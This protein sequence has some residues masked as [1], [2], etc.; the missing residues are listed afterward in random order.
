L[1]IIR[2]FAR[3]CDCTARDVER[4]LFFVHR[5]FQDGL[6]YPGVETRS[7]RTPAVPKLHA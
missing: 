3:L 1:I 4:T 6:P 2:Y 7:K 5:K